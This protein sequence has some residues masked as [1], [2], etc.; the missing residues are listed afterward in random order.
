MEGGYGVEGSSKKGKGLM[1]MDNSVVIVGG[2][3][4][5]GLHSNG[6]NTVKI[7]LKKEVLSFSRMYFSL[8]CW[9]L[10]Y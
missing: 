4:I 9:Q 5:R 7:N 10:Q 3:G 1:D 6:K 2:E 8:R